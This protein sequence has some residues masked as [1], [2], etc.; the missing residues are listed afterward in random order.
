[1]AVFF[2]WLLLLFGVGSP[3]PG[4]NTITVDSDSC[5]TVEPPAPFINFTNDISNGI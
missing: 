1:M 4:G 2:T 5:E 3:A